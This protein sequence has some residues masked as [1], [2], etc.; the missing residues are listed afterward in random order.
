MAKLIRT[1]AFATLMAFMATSAVA[2]EADGKSTVTVGKYIF[3]IAN[4]PDAGE[5]WLVGVKPGA[6]LEGEITI[7]G[8]ATVNGTRYEVTRI[9]DDIGTNW[10]LY[11]AAIKDWPLITKVTIP[12]TIESMH[13]REFLGCT[14]IMEFHVNSGNKRFKDEDGL[15]YYRQGASDEWSWNFFRMPP[16]RTKT[17]FTVPDYVEYVWEN[18]FA[19]NK[20]LKTLILQNYN[21]LMPDWAYG[22]KSIREFDVTAS[23]RYSVKDGLLYYGWNNQSF[24]R[25][26]A[27]PPGLSM[28]SLSIPA[29]VTEIFPGAFS[30]TSI[31]E[32]H[33]PPS[34]NSIGEFAF[35]NAAITTLRY[36]Y[37]N[38]YGSM[39]ALCVDCKNLETV[40]I[41]GKMRSSTKIYEAQFLGCE[42]LKSLSISSS[43]IQL[44][45]RAFYGCKSLKS[46]PFGQLSAIDGSDGND[47]NGNDV[48]HFAY[49]GI[50]SA[51]I[52][53]FC[54]YIP[55]GMFRGSALT[56][57]NLADGDPELEF[58]G[59]DAFRDCRLSEVILPPILGLEKGSFTGNPLKKVVI[60]EH[61]NDPEVTIS[62]SFSGSEDTWYYV[63]NLHVRWDNQ[64]AAG[65]YVTGAFEPDANV[66]SAWTK[67][68]CPARASALY[69]NGSRGEV[70]E[71]FTIEPVSAKSG[72]VIKPAEAASNLDIKIIKVVIGSVSTFQD[73]D[74]WHFSYG[75]DVEKKSVFMRYTVD[76]VEMFTYYPA[77][78]FN[79]AGVDA[80]GNDASTA[81]VTGVYDLTGR[82]VAE[83]VNDAPGGILIVRFSD[84]SA[85]KIIKNE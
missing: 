62:S 19:D 4:G 36:D 65:V 59:E 47:N 52:P 40:E 27:C 50:E 38:V 64:P 16:A 57:V 72:V 75:G 18:A 7:P 81:C 29:S 74:L 55:K 8:S 85:S 42:N 78:T 23:L 80:V 48:E 33:I 67:L 14:G 69:G 44:G 41:T 12:S 25:L 84:G 9:G 37:D 82:R 26:V 31:P 6:T 45:G 83:T 3:R 5:A 34:V 17:K 15:L 79:S 71:M 2:I 77:G 20:T 28:A 24:N 53:S 76:G 10:Y 1:L 30:N 54:E 70:V 43:E 61:L 11:E 56:E 39:K 60:T 73:G 63:A 35:H 13:S 49:S 46:F 51:I 66:P 22:N 68:Y 58:V 32:I 21:T